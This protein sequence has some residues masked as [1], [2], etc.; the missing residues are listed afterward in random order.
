MSDEKVSRLASSNV[1]VKTGYVI[2][3]LI[4][5]IIKA[6]LI[7]M[8]CL[9]IV[10]SVVLVPTAVRVL[11][12]D[13]FG[14]VLTKDPTIK[15]GKIPSGKTELVIIGSGIN[16]TETAKSKITAAFTPHQSTS[17]VK[18]AGGPTG[19]LKIDDATGL[20]SIDGK[21]INNSRKPLNYASVVKN[22]YLLDNQYYVQC[23]KGSCQQGQFYV[24]DQTDILGEVKTND[25]DQPL[26]DVLKEQ[27]S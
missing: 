24:M 17:I 25:T 14:L 9:F 7:I 22:K 18:I 13:N 10:Y 20:A 23:L 8:A 21:T 27:R 4:K 3:S 11:Y 19:H 15:M 16:A 2:G 6:V 12:T 5:R 1:Q 26:I